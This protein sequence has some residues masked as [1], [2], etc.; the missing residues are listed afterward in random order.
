MELSKLEHNHSF[1][2]SKTQVASQ[3]QNHIITN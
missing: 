3:I 1:P 2:Y